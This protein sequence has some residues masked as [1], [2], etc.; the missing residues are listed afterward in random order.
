[1]Y[2]LIMMLCQRMNYLIVAESSFIQLKSVKDLRFIL[3]MFRFLFKVKP[4]DFINRVGPRSSKEYLINRLI[5]DK[6]RFLICY[7]GGSKFK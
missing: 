7:Y 2:H 4:H 1:M 6:P 3:V 5:N